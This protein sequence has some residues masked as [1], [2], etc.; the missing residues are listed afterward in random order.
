[1]RRRFSS[2]MGSRSKRGVCTSTRRGRSTSPS[3]RAWCALREMEEGAQIDYF[4][5]RRS[6]WPTRAVVSSLLALIYM[7]TRAASEAPSAHAPQLQCTHI[8][9]A[10]SN[11]S[12]GRADRLAHL[13]AVALDVAPSTGVVFVAARDLDNPAA[14]GAVL[15]YRRGEPQVRPLALHRAVGALPDG[16]APTELS[17]M[18]VGNAVLLA[19]VA[20]GAARGGDT[21]EV[22]RVEDALSQG[23][24][25][26]LTL[27]RSVTLPGVGTHIT[28]LWAVWPRGVYVTSCSDAHTSAS[29]CAMHL[30]QGAEP[31]WR[32]AE[33]GA[34]TWQRVEYS[35]ALVLASAGLE[36]D[37][38]RIGSESIATSM[39]AVVG[40]PML[41]AI[42]TVRTRSARHESATGSLADAGD[43][44]STVPEL[45]GLSREGRAPA[46]T[47]EATG[48]TLWHVASI[49]SDEAAGV[50]AGGKLQPRLHHRLWV[51]I[52]TGELLILQS[53]DSH[54]DIY[55]APAPERPPSPNAV[56]LELRKV[57]RV[58]ERCMAAVRLPPGEADTSVPP[59]AIGIAR[60]PHGEILA[61]CEGTQVDSNND[62]AAEA[63]QREEL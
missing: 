59:L 33:A 58:A 22:L 10:G 2:S 46:G 53:S 47:P 17:L 16:F 11:R 13:S 9:I 55:S 26:G 63:T 24:P 27:L 31:D 56:G 60:T 50:S 35:C 4:Y 8:A 51:E 29:D 40:S 21:L 18:E 38:D 61:I 62:A 48:N 14:D 19:I 32:A 49:A 5:A 36:L 30:C 54:C 20:N 6:S 15:T 25:T 43:R 57:A 3:R 44:S 52:A 34:G 23:G 37:G 28:G 12:S 42:Y 7:A 39:H 41:K 45:I 1:M